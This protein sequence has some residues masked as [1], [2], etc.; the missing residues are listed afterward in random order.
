LPPLFSAAAAAIQTQ[1]ANLQTPAAAVSITAATVVISKTY[2]EQNPKPSAAAIMASS[3]NNG[4]AVALGTP[5]AQKLTRGNFLF[6]KTLTFPALCVTQAVGLL[7]GT[8]SAPTKTLEAEDQDKEKIQ[9]HKP[10]YAAWVSRDQ[11]VVSFLMNSLSLSLSPEILAL[12]VDLKTSTEI[13]KVITSICTAQSRSRV[14]HLCGA[15][16]SNKKLDMTP[17]TCT[18]EITTS[19]LGDMFLPHPSI[20]C[21]PDDN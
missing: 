4:L 17:S 11:T 5:S 16:N 21:G 18:S 6:W 12:V 2:I 20:N 8:D 10:A 1:Q 15:I 13:L 9:I 14:Q 7:D 19:A 3:S